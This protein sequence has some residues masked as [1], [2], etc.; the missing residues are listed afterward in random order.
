MLEVVVPGAWGDLIANCK[1]KNAK[2][3]ERPPD[4]LSAAGGPLCRHA[5]L[6]ERGRFLVYTGALPKNVAPADPVEEVREE[7]SR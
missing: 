2:C 4:A 5:A 1:V 6:V 3:V 7:R